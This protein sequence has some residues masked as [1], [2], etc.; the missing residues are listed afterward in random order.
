MTSGTCITHTYSMFTL[1]IINK[2][3]NS[4]LTLKTMNDPLSTQHN[5]LTD[6]KV[7]ANA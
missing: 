2:E 1:Y 3:T 4:V 6:K 7:T 5:I